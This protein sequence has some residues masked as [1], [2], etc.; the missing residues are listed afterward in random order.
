MI[1]L[2]RLIGGVVRNVKDH[3]LFWSAL[4]EEVD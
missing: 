4:R 2:S 3:A 1:G